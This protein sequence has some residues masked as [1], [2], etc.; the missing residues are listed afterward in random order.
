MLRATYSDVLCV[1]LVPS[2]KPIIPT[3]VPWFQYVL[4]ATHVADKTCGRETVARFYRQKSKNFTRILSQF[5][6]LRNKHFHEN[7]W[8]ERSGNESKVLLSYEKP[9]PHAIVP[10]QTVIITV[11][12]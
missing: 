2:R 7:P 10:P 3:E 11:I 12:S 8:K 5:C 1:I 9:P 4:F 6:E